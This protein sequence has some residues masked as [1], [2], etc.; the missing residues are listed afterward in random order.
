MSKF[1]LKQ[2]SIISQYFESIDD[3]IHIEMTCKRHRGLLETLHTNPISLTLETRTFFPNIKTLQLYRIIDQPFL[4]D[5]KISNRIYWFQLS[6]TQ[7]SNMIVQKC[8]SN[9]NKIIK[10]KESKSSKSNNSKITNDLSKSKSKD[11]KDSKESNKTN[12]SSILNVN[13]SKENTEMDS[14]TITESI[15]SSISTSIEP[16]HMNS[17]SKMIIM[18]NPN[19]PDDSNETI[20]QNNQNNQIIRNNTNQYQDEYKRI[21]YT[22][23]DRISYGNE[24]PEQVNILGVMTYADV[25]I[26]SII[27]PT[28]VKEIQEGCFCGCKQL[29]TISIPQSVTSLHFG[30]F[31]LTPLTSI[32]LPSNWTLYGNRMINN[33]PHLCALKIPRSVK[34]INGENVKLTHLKSITIPSYVTSIGDYCFSHCSKI[35]EIVIPEHVKKVGDYSFFDC[36]SV[37]SLKVPENDCQYGN[38]CFYGIDV[39]AFCETTLPPNTYI[40]LNSVY[41]RGY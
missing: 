17:F 1:T 27:I 25:P 32:S 11:S 30:T 33:L 21:C 8:K 41:G 18:N 10:G 22:E 12:I 4:E 39:D 23:D 7:Y 31:D 36:V 26:Q 14:E 35:T 6:F 20:I 5:E 24:I 3:F 19:L 9:L 13:N 28:T 37:T 40:D 34:V 29:K 16:I 2:L 38:L 15:T